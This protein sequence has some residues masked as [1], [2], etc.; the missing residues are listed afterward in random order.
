M[1]RL[2]MMAYGL[3]QS[4]LPIGGATVFHILLTGAF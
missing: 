1:A 4:T 3:F 2:N